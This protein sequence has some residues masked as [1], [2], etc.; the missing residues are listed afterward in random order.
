M[1]PLINLDKVLSSLG[2]V[3]LEYRY[4][5]HVALT[6]IIKENLSVVFYT[7]NDTL[8]FSIKG[9]GDLRSLIMEI[10]LFCD[11]ALSTYGPGRIYIK[12]FDTTYGKNMIY[13]VR[14]KRWT[15][16]YKYVKVMDN[17]YRGIYSAL[18]LYP[19]PTSYDAHA[20]YNSL[21]AVVRKVINDRDVFD[22][23]VRTT[24][25]RQRDEGGKTFLEKEILKE[26][27][28]PQSDRSD[29][30][31]RT[32]SLINMLWLTEGDEHI[33]EVQF[34]ISINGKLTFAQY[35]VALRSEHHPTI[36]ISRAT[37]L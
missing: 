1:L 27:D 2:L 32:M 11:N 25:T 13:D 5:K 31:D 7:D 21:G 6:K 23:S 28:F 20:H 33:K 16:V 4:E 37:T 12:L 10:R 3:N 22:L 15:F 18:G 9:D 35:I 29:I 19:R 30:G 14:R 36:W 8:K 34:D 26:R 17:F 24:V